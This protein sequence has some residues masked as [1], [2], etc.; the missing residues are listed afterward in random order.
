MSSVCPSVCLSVTF[1][2]REH[3]GW[4]SS[5]IISRPNSLRLMRSL[6]PTRTIWCIGNTPKLGWNRGSSDTVQD[7]QGYYYGL[8]GSHIRA[9]DW[10][11]RQW[12][13]MTAATYGRGEGTKKKKKESHKQWHFT[14]APRP[15]GSPI[16]PIFGSYCGVTDLVSYGPPSFV[17]IPSVVLLSG[18]AENPTVRTFSA[19]AYTTG[20]GYGPT[21]DIIN[22]I[23]NHFYPAMLRRERLWDRMSSVRPSDS[24]RP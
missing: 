9:F 15:T 6:T 13:W 21:C 17:A 14:H 5:K 23:C 7:D 20:L 12:P 18:V 11:R 8:I 2:Y 16:A 3:R 4:N 22:K 24:V 10:H 19:L 1:K